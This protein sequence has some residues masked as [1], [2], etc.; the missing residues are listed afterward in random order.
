[1]HTKALKRRLRPRIFFHQVFR[2]L[3]NKVN[4]SYKTSEKAKEWVCVSRLVKLPNGPRLQKLFS[5]LKNGLVRFGLRD[6]I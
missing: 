2:Q 3:G 4:V 1:M 5:F 6:E